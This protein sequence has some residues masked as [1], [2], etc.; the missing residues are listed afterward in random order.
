MNKREIKIYNKQR[1]NKNKILN[2]TISES[3]DILYNDIPGIK[4]ENN[5]INNMNNNNTTNNNMNNNTTNNNTTNNNMNNNTTNNNMNNNTTNN[6]NTNNN[7]N[8][9]INN[10]IKN[11]NFCNNFFKECVKKCQIEIIDKSNK[12]LKMKHH[13]D[14]L[15]FGYK[16]SNNI[17]EILYCNRIFTDLL[18]NI[19]DSCDSYID[20]IETDVYSKKSNDDFIYKTTNGM[21]SYDERSVYLPIEDDDDDFLIDY[22]KHKNLIIQE[23]KEY[24]DIIQNNNTNNNLQNNN[25]N[26]NLQNNNTNNINK[27]KQNNNIENNDYKN[28]EDNNNIKPQ[29]NKIKLSNRSKILIKDI[30]YELNIEKIDEITDIKPMFYWYDGD[31]KYDSGIYC[32]PYFNTY[33]KVPFPKIIDINK[34]INKSTITCKYITREECN[35]QKNKYNNER[36]NNDRNNNDRNNNDRNAK[37]QYVHKG[38]YFNKIGIHSRCSKIPDFGN[39]SSLHDDLSDMTLQDMKLIL[40]YGLNDSILMSIWIDYNMKYKKIPKHNMIILDEIN[41]FT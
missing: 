9:N 32:S 30:G 20:E 14:T 12:F 23:K 28:I 24:S 18:K 5:I 27:N 13:K 22:N 21:L 16:L 29:R 25:T 8:N 36:N 4:T 1:Q 6:N 39:P 11:I 40:M 17:K 35:N 34:D 41:R 10:S 2:K 33:V 3:D 19:S 15:K 7:T 37:C 26:N 31:D 38:E